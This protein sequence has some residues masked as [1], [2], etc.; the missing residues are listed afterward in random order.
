MYLRVV[1]CGL[2]LASASVSAQIFATPVQMP[3]AAPSSNNAVLRSGTEVPLRLSE[4]LTTKGK[5]LRVGQRFRLETAE[6]VVV[7]GVTVIP[8]GSPAVGEIT[9]VRNK[10]MW[11]KSGHLGARV[12]YVTVNGR[13]I[14]LSGSF[15][16]KGK[17]GGVGAVA[18]SALVFLPAGFFMTGTSAQVPMGTAV[19]GFVDED[20]ALS[21][22]AGAPLPL[23]V[24]AVVQPV[25][26]PL[27]TVAVDAAPTATMAPS[28]SK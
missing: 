10:G 26:V 20:V 27:P 8:V 2:L 14:R 18:V 15:D 19:K 16:D 28:A 12:L 9:D 3:I 6:P 11:G 4:E 25:S 23:T 1:A 7:Q 24:G 13:Q 21:L 22:A 17:A 5:K